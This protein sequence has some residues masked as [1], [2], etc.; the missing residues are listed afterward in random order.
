[1]KEEWNEEELKI[2]S[3]RTEKSIRAITFGEYKMK[4]EEKEGS[5]KHNKQIRYYKK[6]KRKLNG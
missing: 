6:E 5:K 2:K 1:M 3:I 4:K